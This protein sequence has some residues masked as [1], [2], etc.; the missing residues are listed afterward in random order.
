M[1]MTSHS[2]RSSRRFVR[3]ALAAGFGLLL[4]AQAVQAHELLLAVATPD[5][6]TKTIGLRFTGQYMLNGPFSVPYTINV[7]CLDGGPA[8]PPITGTANGTV[9]NNPPDALAGTFDI[10]VTQDASAL[11]GRTCDLSGSATLFQDGVQYNTAS[12]T[13]GSGNLSIPSDCEVEVFAG[14]TPGYWKQSQHFDSWVGYSPN[15]SFE[16]VFGRDVPGNPTLLAALQGRGGGLVALMRHATAALLNTSNT[17]VNYPY[18]TAQ[19]ISLFQKAFDTGDYE[20]F[21]NMFASLN[22]IG[23]PLN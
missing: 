5:C 9:V 4:G 23:C 16:A 6:E 12:L 15:G 21:K 22:E 3:S 8:V 1:Q 2:I 14:C 17:G 18:T 10:T 19:V 13:D 11:A 7:T 20:T